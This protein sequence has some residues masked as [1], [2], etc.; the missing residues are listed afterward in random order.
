MSDCFFFK[1]YLGEKKNVFLIKW[2][3]DDYIPF[4]LD[5]NAALDY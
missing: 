3:D 5:Q 1:L 4:A 2:N